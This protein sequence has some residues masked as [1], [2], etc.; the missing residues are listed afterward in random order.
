MVVSSDFGIGK[1]RVV[2]PSGNVSIIFNDGYIEG[3]DAYGIYIVNGAIDIK[4]VRTPRKGCAESREIV[5]RLG[6]M[7][8]NQRRY[9]WTIERLDINWMNETMLLCDAY[10]ILKAMLK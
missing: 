3:Y 1:V 6:R 9:E 10:E 2:N 5:A 7:F 8:L 4:Y